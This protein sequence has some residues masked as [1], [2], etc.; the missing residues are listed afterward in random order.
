MV[1]ENAIQEIEHEVEEVSTLL[2]I[3]PVLPDSD[4]YES[5]TDF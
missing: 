4:D 2:D 5:D 3:S 1:D